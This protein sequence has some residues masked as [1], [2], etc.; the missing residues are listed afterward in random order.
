MYTVRQNIIKIYQ[1][2]I[3]YQNGEIIR[4]IINNKIFSILIDVSFD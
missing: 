1:K 2:I 4:I 3:S